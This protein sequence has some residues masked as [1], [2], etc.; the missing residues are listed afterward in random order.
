MNRQPHSSAREIIVAEAISEVVSEL[1]MV[2]VGDYIAYIRLE[3]FASVADLV[4][5]AAELYFQPG[6]L[7]L[8]HGGDAIVAWERAPMIVL[9][10]ELRPQGAVVYF[11]LTLTD[12]HA[13]IEVHYVWFDNPSEDPAENNAFL[14]DAIEHSRVRKTVPLAA[15]D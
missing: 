11:A 14:R 6:T 2:D 4:D 1:R 13:S 9:D 7:S 10:L 3:R 5:T 15:M 12:D 8:G